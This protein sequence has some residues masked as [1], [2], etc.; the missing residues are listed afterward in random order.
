M[1]SG[2]RLELLKGSKH[3]SQQRFD[4]TLLVLVLLVLGLVLLLLTCLFLSSTSL[5]SLFVR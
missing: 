5:L 2:L 4:M 3:T 1:M